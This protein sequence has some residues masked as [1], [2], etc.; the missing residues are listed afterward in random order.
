MTVVT[1]IEIADQVEG[2]FDGSSIGYEDLLQYATEHGA[3]DE[4]LTTLGRLHGDTY[5]RLPDLW[6][7]LRDV[8]VE[9]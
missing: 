2:L 3:R 9:L 5:R 8:P 1:R 4:V 7:E 6:G